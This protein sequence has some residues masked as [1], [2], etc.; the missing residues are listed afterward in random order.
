[1]SVPLIIAPAL[2]VGEDNVGTSELIGTVFFV[3]GI[4]TLLQSIIGVR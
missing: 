3:S 1:M 2:C 4:V